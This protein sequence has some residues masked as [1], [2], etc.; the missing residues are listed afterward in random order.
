MKEKMKNRISTPENKKQTF[1]TKLHLQLYSFTIGGAVFCGQIY[2][3][4]EL[5]QS[6][7]D[8]HQGRY[9]YCRIRDEGLICVALSE[10]ALC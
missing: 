7:Y 9:D 10:T 4:T 6:I 3:R 1:P 5:L 2:N 8:E